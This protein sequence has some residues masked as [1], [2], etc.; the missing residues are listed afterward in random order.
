MIREAVEAL[1]SPTTNVAVRG[2]IEARYPGT[3]H[4]TIQCQITVCTVNQPSRVHYPNGNQPRP[5]NDPRYDFLYRP[6]RGVLEWYDAA[7][8]GV[9]MI[10][11]DAEGQ[12]FIRREGG[13][14]AYPEPQARSTRP[15]GSEWRRPTRELRDDPSDE[16][17]IVEPP[18]LA[19]AWSQWR[20]LAQ[21]GDGPPPRAPERPGVYQ[22]RCRLDNQE[23]E[24]VYIGLSSR[25]VRGLRGRINDHR[26]RPG[27]CAD[28]L[29]NKQRFWDH[30]REPIEVRW[31]V[32]ERS[33]YVEAVLRRQFKDEHG[34]LPRFNTDG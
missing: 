29:V 26:S 20:P 7:D 1:G 4:G 27:S 25:G 16:I 34:R 2:W 12:S 14:P 11:R 9:W 31:A 13:E 15:R 24:I 33:H 10:E 3:N 5:C 23:C 21:Q 17:E 28:N 32:T 6:E 19:L 8:H 30:A 18:P 22:I